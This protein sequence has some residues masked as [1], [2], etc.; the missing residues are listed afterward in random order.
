ML[1]IALTIYHN[2]PYFLFY[3]NNRKLLF[4]IKITH[5]FFRY[6]NFFIFFHRNYH[7]ILHC[8][9]VSVI[10]IINKIKQIPE[11][12]DGILNNLAKDY[13]TNIPD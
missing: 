12:I 2:N 9:E 3:F 8:Y 6:S 11:N 10:D 4:L 13:S 5:L 7:N 1:P